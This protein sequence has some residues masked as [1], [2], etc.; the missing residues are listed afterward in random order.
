MVD[1]PPDDDA[2][3]HDDAAAAPMIPAAALAHAEVVDLAESIEP[4][5][6]VPAHLRPRSALPGQELLRI[7]GPEL[8]CR[9]V[10]ELEQIYDREAST[11][12]DMRIHTNRG[13]PN[14]VDFV[15]VQA[16]A[17]SRPTF[18]ASPRR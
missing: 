18:G 4:Y 16:F 7:L 17:A 8:V 14:R 15:P 11:H 1:K 2:L 12:I 5:Q 9:I 10:L 13:L 3:T 6:Q